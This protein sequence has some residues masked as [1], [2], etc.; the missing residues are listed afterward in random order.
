MLARPRR[1]EAWGL[2]REVVAEAR[3]DRVLGLA[4]ETAFFSV[5]S[6][7]PG[8]L[9]AT[10]LVEAGVDLDFPCAWRAEAGLDVIDCALSTMSQGTSQPPT[11]SMA[12]A[13]CW[14][15]RVVVPSRNRRAVA[16]AR[17]ALAAESKTLPARRSIC[18]VTA[19]VSECSMTMAPSKSCIQTPMS[20]ARIWLCSM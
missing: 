9:I 10:S 16:D 8:L 2:G 6:L 4:A 17:P 3:K 11:E 20:D 14:D 19:V 15:E 18:T 13:I 7:F 12:W 1:R 5:L